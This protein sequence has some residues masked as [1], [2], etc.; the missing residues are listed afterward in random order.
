MQSLLSAKCKL[1]GERHVG[2]GEA[3]LPPKEA[4][5]PRVKAW[6]HPCPSVVSP[7]PPGGG[8]PP[9]PLDSPWLKVGKAACGQSL[10]PRS[11]G[12]LLV[13]MSHS[14]CYATVRL[15]SIFV[16]TCLAFPEGAAVSSWA[17][18]AVGGCPW[19]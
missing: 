15:T 12:L 7:V 17:A 13:L 9:K 5:G 10:T 1:S 6:A 11:A 14:N 8:R 4:L 2:P 16:S 19:T 3:L 18:R